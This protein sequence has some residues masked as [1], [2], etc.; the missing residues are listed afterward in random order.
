MVIFFKLGA[1]KGLFGRFDL[2][3]VVHWLIRNGKQYGI[4][5]ELKDVFLKL[6]GNVTDNPKKCFK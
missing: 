4:L 3:M 1:E 2:F 6:L 5:A